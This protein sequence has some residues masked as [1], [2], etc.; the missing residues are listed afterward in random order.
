MLDGGS[1]RTTRAGAFWI[2]TLTNGLYAVLEQLNPTEPAS[3]GLP[4]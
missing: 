4:A 1:F 3:K 2:T